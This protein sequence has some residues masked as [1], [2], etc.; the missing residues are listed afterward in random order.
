MTPDARAP[1]IERLVWEGRTVE[2]RYEPDWG[3]M[4]EL[5]PGRQV[6]HLELQTIDPEMAPLPVTG[7]GYRSQFI[8]AGVVE[9]AG[10]PAAYARQ[11][12]DSEARTPAW[13]RTEAAWR[14]LDLFG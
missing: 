8:P 2:V 4:S 5:G 6:A 10:G 13:R 3:S 7:T 14:Q 9:E 1:L 12:L 11:W